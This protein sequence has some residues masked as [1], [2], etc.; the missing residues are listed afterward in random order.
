MESK[1]SFFGAGL[2][3]LVLTQLLSNRLSA[4]RLRFMCNEF[5]VMCKGKKS[6]TPCNEILCEINYRV[7]KKKMNEKKDKM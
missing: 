3:I 7:I 6:V 4:I 2:A 5:I 1:L